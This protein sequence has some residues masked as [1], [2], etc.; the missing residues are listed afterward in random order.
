MKPQQDPLLRQRAPLCVPT[1]LLQSAP[2][3]HRHSTLP[4]HVTDRPA[5]HPLCLLPQAAALPESLTPELLLPSDLTLPPCARPAAARL[6]G[7]RWHG[8]AL[9]TLLWWP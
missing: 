9:A 6:L 3:A 1:L 8:G 2:V 7:Y 4:C 5:S